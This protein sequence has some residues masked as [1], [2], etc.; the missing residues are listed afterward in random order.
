MNVSS[1][2]RGRLS[3]LQEMG[4]ILRLKLATKEHYTTTSYQVLPAGV[5]A[6]KSMKQVDKDVVD[7]FLTDGVTIETAQELVAAGKRRAARRDSSTR[8][9]KSLGETGTSR[10]VRGAIRSGVGGVRALQR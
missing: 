8:S 2:G 5:A 3:D 7:A 10:A 4:L 6:L 1:E 9:T